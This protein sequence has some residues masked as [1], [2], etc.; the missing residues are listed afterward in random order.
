MALVL[1]VLS[2]SRF[3]VPFT[4]RSEENVRPP[5]RFHTRDWETLFTERI[6]PER[7]HLP[8]SALNG[9]NGMHGVDGDEGP[10]KAAASYFRTKARPSPKVAKRRVRLL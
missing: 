4:R 7:P 10:G 1:V 5:E 8:V 9:E 3:A 6:C 2:C